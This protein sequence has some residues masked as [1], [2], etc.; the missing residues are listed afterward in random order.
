[1]WLEGALI[2]AVINLNMWAEKKVCF[3][4]FILSVVIN[5]WLW[6]QNDKKLIIKGP[7]QK[8][9]NVVLIEL[10]LAWLAYAPEWVEAIE[11]PTTI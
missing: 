1:M 8:K 9:K 3:H 6:T 4:W 10:D 7:K 2:C 11:T 5:S